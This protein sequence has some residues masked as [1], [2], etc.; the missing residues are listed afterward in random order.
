MV[1]P[2]RP[3]IAVLL[4][5]GLVAAGGGAGPVSPSASVRVV[6][7]AASAAG[8]TKADSGWLPLFNGKDL[9]G[10]NV[11][12]SAKGYVDAKT[13]TMFTPDSGRVHANGPYSLLVTAKEYSHYRARVDYRFAPNVGDKANAG[14]MILFDTEAAKTHKEGLR[15]RSI[16]INFRRD[17]NFPGTLWA[18]QGY[19]PYISTTVKSGSQAYLPRAQGGVDWICEPWDPDKRVVQST[20]PVGENPPGE[21]NRLEARVY[22]DSALILL[23]GNPRTSGW[24][25]QVRGAPL[26]STPSKRVGVTSGGLAIQAEGSELWY[27]DWE[28]Q[29]LDPAT[30]APLHARRGCTDPLQAGYDPRAVMDDGSCGKVAVQEP[31][32]GPGKKGSV[33]LGAAVKAFAGPQ[34]GAVDAEGRALGLSLPE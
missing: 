22:G 31:G 28:I 10:L 4:A 32:R 7:L 16:E 29:E 34:G 33:A 14:M 30:R 27:R 5:V 23:N 19:G 12:V 1:D 18:A 15:P 20:L 11:F 2:V 13:Q 17:G 3:L 21:W 24:H 8:P 26:D 6:G 9:A 25:F